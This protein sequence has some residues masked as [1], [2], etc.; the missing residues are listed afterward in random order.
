MATKKPSSG[1][2]TDI[3]SYRRS[4]GGSVTG[5]L[6]GGIKDRLKEKF[7]ARQLINQK[8]LMTALFPGLKT[9]QAK[10]AA[11]ELSSSSMR[12]TSFDEIKPILETISYS[13]K[14]TAKN[15]MVLPALHRDVNVIRQ[16][17]VKLVK[18]KG[19]DARTKAD[20]YFVKAKDREDKYERELKKERTKQL[21]TEKL[22]DEED[23]KT[24][25][26]L[27]TV[28][29]T[30]IKA[31][32]GIANAIISLGKAILGVF[33]FLAGIIVDT[34]I[35]V[36][37]FLFNSLLDVG[38]ILGPLLTDLLKDFFKK[39][40]FMK[41]FVRGM[42][43]LVWRF[44][45]GGGAL[46]RFALLLAPF[47]LGYG[48]MLSKEAEKELKLQQGEVS[49]ESELQMM[50]AT[51]STLPTNEKTFEGDELKNAKYLGLAGE[52]VK[53]K[54]LFKSTEGSPI[55]GLREL[56]EGYQNEMKMKYH[57]EIVDEWKNYSRQAYNLYAPGLA[58]LHDF[59]LTTKEAK[60][61]GD[62]TRD[63]QLML[64]KEYELGKEK[65]KY[66]PT[67]REFGQYHKRVET[68][69]GEKDK[70]KNEMLMLISKYVGEQ[71]NDTSLSG[72]YRRVIENLLQGKE[73]KNFFDQFLDTSLR[74]LGVDNFVQ[75]I[76]NEASSMASN[77]IDE[78]RDRFNGMI[79]SGIN[80]GKSYLSDLTS[81]IETRTKDF[82]AS[83]IIG[84]T[85]DN[86]AQSTQASSEPKVINAE[87]PAKN[88][89]SPKELGTP[90]SAWNT[91]FIE[92]YF[93]ELLKDPY[94]YK[95]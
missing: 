13:T 45:T 67:S 6:A 8:G 22:S 10:T 1:R 84:L 90:A 80:T 4:Q 56:P 14:M 38:K 11:S 3:V 54:G 20:M 37:K 50:G 27:G 91:D 48:F 34:I 44:L 29:S 2:L 42:V 57:P 89:L 47:L 40:L 30:I 41:A 75:E 25:G 59:L 26:F 36:G 73:K 46:M 35:G 23:K 58:G 65:M 62:K 95:N 92:K 18:M 94:T 71:Y 31:L 39:S 66:D 77:V 9:Y 69:R 64:Q 5:S 52:D 60:E 15:T 63:Y 68:I 93:F 86:K 79:S 83:N 61:Y 49:N 7:D 32:G 70:L 51:G 82:Y 74:E 12:S 81:N 72:R 85:N 21:K 87:A 17:M 28:F 78:G 76:E 33:K 55:K 16:N 24:K 43:G 88:N 53:K 19:G